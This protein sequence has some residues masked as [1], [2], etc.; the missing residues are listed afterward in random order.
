MVLAAP[1]GA[2]VTIDPGEAAKGSDAVLSLVVPNENDTTSTTK[3]EVQLPRDR[4]LADVRVQPKPGWTVT[5]T[6]RQLAKPVTTDEGKVSEVVD[7]ITWDGGSIGPGQFDLF[8]IAAGPLPTKGKQLVF[9][10]LQTYSDG[11]VVR[12][13]ETP[14]KGGGEPE[15]PAPVLRLEA[16]SEAHGH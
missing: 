11:T 4:P 1:A 2:H 10:T 7:T 8:T 6:T 5:T 9:K 13:I 15:H 12:W 14:T 16:A 3:I